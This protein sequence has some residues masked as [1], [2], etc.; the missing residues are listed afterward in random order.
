MD[1]FSVHGNSFSVCL[2]NLR[3]VLQRCGEKHLI[4]N[5]EKCHFMVRNGIVLGHKI[6]EQEI[7]VDKAKIEVM[8]SLHPPN[9]V[10]GIQS[11]LGHDGFYMRFIKDF[12][13]ILRPLTRLLCKETKFE[14][15]SDCLAAF[16]MIKGALIS[17]PIVQPPDWDLPFDIMTV[18]SQYYLV[19][20]K[21]VVHTY[22]ATLRMKIDEE[23]TLDDT[24]PVEKVYSID[25]SR[26][27]AQVFPTDCSKYQEHSFATIKK[28]YPHLPWFT[29]I[30]NFLAAE[31]EPMEFTGNEKRKFIRDAHHYF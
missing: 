1:G 5:W 15:D 20:Y 11:F 18:I 22:H 7:E 27:S 31:K 29:E 26:P 21:V 8:M 6:S 3:R 14:F 25:L 13:K 9:S 30:A 10:K 2:S 24:L 12:S 16:H 19:G 17:A 23:T 4:L 28:R